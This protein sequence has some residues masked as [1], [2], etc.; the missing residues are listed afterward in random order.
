MIELKGSEKLPLKERV[1][2][3]IKL[4]RL[5]KQGMSIKRAIKECQKEIKN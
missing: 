5:L 1:R 3:H 2:L 4:L